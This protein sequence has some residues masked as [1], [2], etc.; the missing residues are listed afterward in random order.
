MKVERILFATDFSESAEAAFG[1]A[2]LVAE[3]LGAELHLLHAVVLHEHDP[4]NPSERFPESEEIFRSLF[5]IADSNMSS[6][7]E[8]SGPETLALK[9][10]KRRGLSAS[11]VIL[12]YAD[13]IDADLIV[14]GTHGR[15]G[16]ARLLMGSVAEAVT[17]HASC[18]VLTVHAGARSVRDERIKTILVPVDFSET[19]PLAIRHAKELGH[20]FK[21][22][23]ALLYVVE[24]VPY[25]YFHVPSESNFV[26]RQLDRAR[27]ALAKLADETL[28]GAIRYTTS[29][30][31]G[32]SATEILKHA[33]EQDAGLLVIGTHGLGAVERLLLGSTAE[34]VIREAP[35]PVFVV[36]SKG[37]SLV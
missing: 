37:K 20:L 4:N 12:S 6:L 22:A 15:T 21:A 27:E 18:P 35:C 7:L 2:L 30:R 3:R 1:R 28:G 16:A 31:S 26:Q 23:L 33:R 32:R 29:V 19:S 17:R 8:R 11:D 36:K 25:P 13:E 5:E 9:E 14:M 34:Q 24:K 10:V